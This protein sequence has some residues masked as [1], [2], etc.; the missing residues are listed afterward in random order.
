MSSGSKQGLAIAVETLMGTVN[1]PF[2]RKKLRHTSC[3]I[4][5]QTT[6]TQS[7]EIREELISSGEYKTSA[8]F[9]GD[10]VG[11]LSYGTYDDLFSAA[12]HKE[13]TANV[14]SIGSLIKSFSVL[15]EYR[16]S[17]GY[18]VFKGMQVTAMTIEV[19]EEGMVKVTFSLQGT[20]R[21]PVTFILPLGV[22]TPET[23]TKLFTNVGVGDITIDGQSMQDIACVTAF[24][25]TIEFTTEAQKCLGKGLSVGKIMSTGV[26]ITGSA[27]LAWGDEAASLN[28]LKYTDTPASF[29][30]P[31]SDSE[32]ADANKYII[33]IPEA[34]LQGELPTGSRTDLLQFSLNY[35]VR[36]QSPTLTRVPKP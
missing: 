19:P 8:A 33:H 24:T 25:M 5:G 6:G 36:N 3:T 31:L 12:F 23:T 2:A 29:T 32:D 30:I 9:A 27:T 10:I 35:T 18:H 21:D 7:D 22:V 1:S 13:W 28:E 11:E 34:T 17:G 16:D 4:D 20:G 26:N 15:R 14:L